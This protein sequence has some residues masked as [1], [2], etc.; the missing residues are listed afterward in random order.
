M[1]LCVAASEESEERYELLI[2]VGLLQ[3]RDPI[4]MVVKR[5]ILFGTCRDQ[6]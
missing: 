3:W 5:H 6:S 1:T 4:D 2:A